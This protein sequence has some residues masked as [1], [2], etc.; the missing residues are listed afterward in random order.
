MYFEETE[1]ASLKSVFHLETSSQSD[2]LIILRGEIKLVL[3]SDHDER[4]H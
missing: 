3:N 1:F 4:T 2:Y